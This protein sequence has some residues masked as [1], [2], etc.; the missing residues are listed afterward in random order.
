MQVVEM[1]LHDEKWD[2]PAG[3]ETANLDP[4]TVS[5]ENQQWLNI[6]KLV[7]WSGVWNKDGCRIRINNTWNF[8]LLR[9][10]L[11]NYHDREVVE[12]LQFGWPYR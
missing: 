9:N 5:S 12:F 7:H 1:G 3:S 11:V 8:E 4:A 2:Y 6:I 10:L